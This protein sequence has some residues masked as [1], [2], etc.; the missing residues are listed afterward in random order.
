MA[1]TRHSHNERGPGGGRSMKPFNRRPSAPTVYM[2]GRHGAP[3]WPARALPEQRQAL[4]K[5][6][7]KRQVKADTRLAAKGGSPW[8]MGSRRRERRIAA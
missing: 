7:T 8:L 4:P 6:D 2:T 1:G 5:A 3:S